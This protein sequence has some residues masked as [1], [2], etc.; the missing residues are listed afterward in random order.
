MLLPDKSAPLTEATDVAIDGLL[1]GRVDG[2]SFVMAEV[3]PGRHRV[4]APKGRYDEATSVD[5]APDSV[6][7]VELGGPK[8]FSLYW[9]ARPRPMDAATARRAVVEAHMAPSSWPGTPMRPR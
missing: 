7:F 3:A 1:V 4:S 2:G 6:Y 9:H 8:K 5:A